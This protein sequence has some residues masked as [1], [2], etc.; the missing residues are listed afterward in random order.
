[1]NSLSPPR[2]LSIMASYVVV[3][4]DV[5]QLLF[6]HVYVLVWRVLWTWPHKDISIN[7]QHLVFVLFKFYGKWNNGWQYPAVIFIYN[8]TDRFFGCKSPAE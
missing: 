2:S 8:K 4:L 7:I 5:L 1:M 3:V 6:G